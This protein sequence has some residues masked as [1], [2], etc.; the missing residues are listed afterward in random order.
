VQVIEFPSYGD[1]LRALTNGQAD[2]TG[3]STTSGQLSELEASPRGISWIELDPN[4]EAI[5]AGMEKVAPIFS[6]YLETIGAG[7]TGKAPVNLAAYRYPMITVYADASADE[8]YG[9]FK[10]LDTVFPDFK[11]SAPIMARWDI[12]VAGKKPMD[13]PFHEG[14]VRYL[15]E[16]GMWDDA[17]QKWNDA[18][19]KQITDLR[20]A[21]AAWAPGAAGLSDEAFAAEWAAA[22]DAIMHP[23]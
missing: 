10:A 15:K 8:V 18:A 14:A 7:I 17:S 2:A 22:R 20:A 6:P 16:K 13:A 4:D 5:W 9:F 1:S 19:V 21:W 23:A 11:D 12:N 3:A